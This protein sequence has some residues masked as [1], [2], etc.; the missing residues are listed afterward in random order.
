MNDISV[1]MRKAENISHRIRQEEEN[2]NS[3]KQQV[4][5]LEDYIR[6]N[7]ST[8]KAAKDY[9]QQH[10][11]L[12]DAANS[13]I[14]H[15]HSPLVLAQHTFHLSYNNMKSRLIENKRKQ[16]E[17]IKEEKERVR[18][19]KQEEK[20]E[21]QQR[22]KQDREEQRRKKQE[23][24]DAAKEADK[25]NLR[26]TNTSQAISIKSLKADKDQ[27]R[28]TDKELYRGVLTVA[29][30]VLNKINQRLGPGPMYE[31]LQY[32]DD[33]QMNED[34]DPDRFV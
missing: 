27:Q 14:K 6:N 9:R 12:Y 5:Q 11:P 34:Y 24:R 20:Q 33:E 25:E 15:H 7:I 18:K 10:Q 1:L 19:Q 13:I 4:S 8:R 23:E 31:Q 30:E 32:D 3:I 28:E 2:E 22:K 26:S 21:E 29:N 17:D 16:Q